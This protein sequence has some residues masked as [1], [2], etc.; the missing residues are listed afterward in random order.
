MRTSVAKSELTLATPT[1]REDRRQAANT[2]DSTAQ[3]CHDANAELIGDFQN[4]AILDIWN[5][6]LEK[7]DQRRVHEFVIIRNVEA[8]DARLPEAWP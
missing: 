1:L 8:D 5:A 6:C 7:T 4:Q 2:A 3:N